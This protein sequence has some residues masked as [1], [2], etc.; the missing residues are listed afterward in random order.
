VRVQ[1]PDTGVFF[2]NKPPARATHRL[3]YG[4]ALALS[5]KHE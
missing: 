1:G 3:G 4:T 5:E 2:R